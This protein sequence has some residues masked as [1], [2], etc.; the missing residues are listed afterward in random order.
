MDT[1]IQ[2]ISLG[3]N[4]MVFV[5]VGASKLLPINVLGDGIRKVGS[6]LASL[7]SL[8]DGVLLID[9]LENGLH[10]ETQKI[11]WKGILANL[12]DSKNQLFVATHSKE[13][14]LALK[15][16]METDERKALQNE[17]AA[18]STNLDS[19]NTL[20]MYEYD[21]EKFAFSISNSIE[22]RGGEF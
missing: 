22:I 6:I 21:F 3:R 2:D 13:C 4:E 11:L 10:Y 8:T 12:A 9:E 14:L 19:Q 15:E 18:F 16:A 1:R 20:K 7:F 17:F 5:D